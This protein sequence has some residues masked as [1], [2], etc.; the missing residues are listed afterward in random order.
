MDR[1]I[2]KSVFISTKL[3]RRLPLISNFL[4]NECLQKLKMQLRLFIKVKLIHTTNINF[5]SN[6]FFL[7]SFIKL[8]IYTMIPTF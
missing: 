8:F 1:E 2:R 3:N 6:P 5:F 4:T 7:I